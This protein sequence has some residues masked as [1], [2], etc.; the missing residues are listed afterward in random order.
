MKT[1]EQEECSFLIGPLLKNKK[2][3]IV[4]VAP[5]NDAKYNSFGD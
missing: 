1:R 5:E 3:E 4:F 2:S